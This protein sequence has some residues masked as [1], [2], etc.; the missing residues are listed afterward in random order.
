M[1]IVFHLH[2]LCFVAILLTSC[3]TVDETPDE[4]PMLERDQREVLGPGGQ[5]DRGQQSP[6]VP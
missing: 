3:G 2:W 4:N 6:N 5:V 1:K